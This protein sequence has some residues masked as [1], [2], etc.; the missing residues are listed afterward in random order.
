MESIVW[1]LIGCNLIMIVANIHSQ[2]KIKDLME[3]IE[4][5]H[6]IMDEHGL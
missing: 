4:H 2:W 5:C 1:V 3:E 6:K